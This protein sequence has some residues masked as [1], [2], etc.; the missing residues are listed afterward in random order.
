M[1]FPVILRFHKK[2]P[3]ILR[4]SLEFLGTF[5]I[6]QSDFTFNL[7]FLRIPGNSQTLFFNLGISRNSK[8]QFTVKNHT[9]HS[10]DFL[11]IFSQEFLRIS[12]EFLGILKVISQGWSAVHGF[13]SPGSTACCHLYSISW[14][15]CTFVLHHAVVQSLGC[16]TKKKK[17][18]YCRQFR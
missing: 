6:T 13:Q 3:V 4:N 18:C 15:C 1:T 14:I 11:R 7:E 9:F 12:Q 8:F 10:Q 16:F 2:F 17:V 5:Q